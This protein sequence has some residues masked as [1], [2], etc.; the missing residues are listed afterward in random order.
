MQNFREALLFSGKINKTQHSVRPWHCQQEYL[1]M[2]SEI[3][4]D[5]CMLWEE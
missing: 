1:L 2:I 5:T 4:E 3:N